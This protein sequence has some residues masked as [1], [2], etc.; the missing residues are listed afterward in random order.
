MSSV[1]VYLYDISMGMAK[2]MS[3][4]LLG[5]QNALDYIPHTSV[6]VFGMEYFFGMGVQRCIPGQSGHGQ[7][8]KVLDYGHTEVPSELFEEWLTTAA[9]KYNTTSYHLL[10]LNCNNFTNDAIE[11]LSGSTLPAEIVTLPQQ[12]MST[13]LGQ[14]IKPFIEQFFAASNNV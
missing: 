10:D 1:K 14:M 2:T 11:F 13:P 7:P 5:P 12:V 3:P 4:M 8:M 6:V 9:A